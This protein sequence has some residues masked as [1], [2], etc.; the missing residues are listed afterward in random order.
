MP[1]KVLIVDDERDIIKVTKTRLES[2]GFEVVCAYDGLSG[3]DKAKE[4]KP[5]IV[6]LDLF[7]PV[8]HG[9]EVCKK[10]KQN[11]DTKN[12]PIILFSAGLC[13]GSCP[14]EAKDVGAVDFIAKPF[15]DEELVDKIKFY[16]KER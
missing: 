15:D 11:P 12:I 3:L 7:M 13:K 16:T 1:T 14:K 8:M 10:L 4:A 2:K 5:D 6:L 9:Y